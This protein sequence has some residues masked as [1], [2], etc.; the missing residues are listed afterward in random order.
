MFTI[1]PMLFNTDGAGSGETSQSWGDLLSER[2]ESYDDQT[3]MESEDLETVED[4]VEEPEEPEL[5]GDDQESEEES[6][7]EPVVEEDP[8]FDL[9]EELG[10]L[11]LSELKNGYRRNKDY[12]QKTQEVAAQRREVESLRES[13]K[14]AQDLQT[15]MDS[16]PWVV[17]QINQA[18]QTFQQ[19]GTLPLEELMDGSEYGQYINHLLVENN[20]LTKELEG[21]K[22]EYEGVKLSADMTRLSHELKAEYGDLVTDEYMQQLQERGKSEKLSIETMKEIADGKLAKESMQRNK[23]TSKEVAA[24][25]IQTLQET[26]KSAPAR[27]KTTSGSPANSAPD[28]AKMSW[29]DVIRYGDER[30]R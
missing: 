3:V 9:G 14:P 12:T 25:T 26:K 30:K 23:R 5:D 20:R 6:E 1:K 21:V 2:A 24:K 8:E 13:L 10:K 29:A 28:F 19:T 22:G 27:P 7:N 4:P 17:G 16:N 11:K 18:I 15:F